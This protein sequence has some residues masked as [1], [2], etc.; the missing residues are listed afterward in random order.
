MQMKLRE[1]AEERLN[2]GTA[3][4]TRGWHTGTQALTLLYNL[5]STHESASDALK[6]LH[7]LQVHQ[8]ELDLQHEQAEQDRRQLV[9]ELTNYTAL[10]DLAPFGYLMLDPEG[11][12]VAANRIATDWL[13]GKAGAVEEWGGRR[14]EDLLAPECRSTIRDVLVSLRQGQG[15]QDCAM[16]S[17]ASG[18]H[19]QAVAAAAL[20][21]QVLIAFA[22]PGP[23]PGH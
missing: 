6:F 23:E 17:R 10:F 11:L 15:R 18:A 12:V 20:G 8:V 9:G 13:A 22:P 19:A 5:A 7:E 1:N 2:N 16:Q 14:I 3:P 21:G 4:I